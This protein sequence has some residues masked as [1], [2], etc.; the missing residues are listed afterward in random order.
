MLPLAPLYRNYI[1]AP[2]SYLSDLIKNDKDVAPYERACCN[3]VLTE[4]RGSVPQATLRNHSC[5]LLATCVVNVCKWYGPGINLALKRTV[6][7]E[8]FFPSLPLWNDCRC[9][10][11]Q[12]NRTLPWEQR[13]CSP[14]PTNCQLPTETAWRRCRF[15]NYGTDMRRSG[16]R[17]LGPYGGEARVEGESVLL[18]YAIS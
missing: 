3:R 15:V 5:L 8:V 6:V 7:K 13:A 17:T 12:L 11:T 2:L 9:F 4:K 1:I 14:T 16:T 10:V 18:T